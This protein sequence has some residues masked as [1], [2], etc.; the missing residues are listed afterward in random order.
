[1]C[2]RSGLLE[3]LVVDVVPGIAGME[4]VGII[5]VVQM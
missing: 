2:I 1:M 5:F 3:T 4:S